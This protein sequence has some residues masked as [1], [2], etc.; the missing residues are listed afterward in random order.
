MDIVRDYLIKNE[1]NGLCNKD[2]SSEPCSCGLGNLMPCGED[3]SNCE[4]SDTRITVVE[5][6]GS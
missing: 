5:S 3:A 6:D 2:P 4:A 1:F